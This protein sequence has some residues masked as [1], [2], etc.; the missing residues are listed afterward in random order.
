MTGPVLQVRLKRGLWKSVCP[1]RCAIHLRAGE[2]LGMVGTS[3]AGKTTLV[4]ALLG[5]LPGAP[6]RPRE[7]SS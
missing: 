3:G 2:M 1:D 5:L 4:M 6:A 7:K